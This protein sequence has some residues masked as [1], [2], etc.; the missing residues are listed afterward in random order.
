FAESYPEFSPDGRWLAYCSNETGQDEVYV[1]PY[2]GAGKRVRISL[3]GGQE[4]AWSKDGKELFYRRFDGKTTSMMSLRFT[5][6]DA[7]FKPEKPVEL[8]PWNFAIGAFAR[9]YDVGPDGRFVAMQR[10]PD[11]SSGWDK[12]VFPSAI[13]IVLNWSQELES[14]VKH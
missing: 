9:V 13:R 4:P 14:L 11:A 10:I 12:K 1:Q 8:F 7:V 6:C 5:A 3:G 2:P